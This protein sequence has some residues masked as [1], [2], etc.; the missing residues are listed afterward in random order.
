VNNLLLFR[1]V[2]FRTVK[3]FGVTEL[4]RN[5]LILLVGAGRFERSPPCAQGRFRTSRKAL[6]INVEACWP[7]S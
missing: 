5:W 7:L 6:I 4:Y 1:P 3:N 2:T